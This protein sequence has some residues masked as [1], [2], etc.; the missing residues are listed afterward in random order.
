MK[1]FKNQTFLTLSIIVLGFFLAGLNFV[2][3]ENLNNPE[4]DLNKFLGGQVKAS[5]VL[6]DIKANQTL[7]KSVVRTNEIQKILPQLPFSDN[8]NHFSI[9]YL[10][11]SKLIEIDVQAT[12]INDYRQRKLLAEAKLVEL[13][14][15]NPC[16]LV[17]IWAIPSQ[18]I[19][20]TSKDDLFTTGCPR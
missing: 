15:G 14:S 3:F 10:P 12:N 16:Y 9:V 8:E 6:P 11:K 17:A 20:K 7:D 19:G 1:I 13:G 4:L 5:P 2:I 18:L